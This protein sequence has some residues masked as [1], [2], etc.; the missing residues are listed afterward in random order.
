MNAGELKVVLKLDD[1]KFNASLIDA[2]GKVKSFGDSAEKS[3]D[4]ADGSFGRLAKNGLKYAALG[5]AGFASVVGG[6]AIKGG[7]SRALDIEDAQAKLKGL[8]HDASSVGGIMESALASVKGTAYGLDAAAT[9]AAT[10]V[11]AGVKPGK[12]LTKYLSLAADAATIAG[13]SMGDMG[14][15][16]NKV[17]TVNAAYNDS[18]LE[19]SEKGLPVYQWLSKE[20][21]VSTEQVKKLAS[22]G[23]VSSE[24]FQKAIENNIAGAALASGNTFRGAWANLL[25]SLS[26]IGQQIVTGPLN[27]LRD[28]F[29]SLTK[30]IDDNS[31]TI[32]GVVS[33]LFDSLSVIATGDFKGGMFGG[34]I[35]EDSKYVDILLKVHDA[36]G[37]VA[38]S[39]KVLVTGDFSKGMFG[40]ALSEDSKYVDMLFDI[41]D[42]IGK[43]KDA[44]GDMGTSLA[45]GNYNKLGEQIGSGIAKSVEV[46]FKGLSIGA[47]TLKSWFSRIDWGK[48]GVDIGTG[49]IAFVLGLVVGLFSTEALSAAASFIASNWQAVLITAITIAFLPAKLLGPVGA[50]M[51]KFTGPLGKLFANSIVAPIRGLVEPIRG[52]FGFIFDGLAGS[53][54]G[55]VATVGNIFK[56]FGMI[57]IAPVKIAIDYIA[58]LIWSLPAAIQQSLGAMASIAKTGLAF[59]WDAFVSVFSPAVGWFGG[60][61]RGAWGAIVNAFSGVAGFFSGVWGTIVGIFGRIGVA[62]G[63]AIGGTFKSAINSVLRGAVNLINGFIH[64]INDVVGI[65]NKIPGVK[66]GKIGD[67]GIP[68]LAAGGIVTAPTLAVIGEGSESEAVLPLSKLKALLD[69]SDSSGSR[70]NDPVEI[71]QNVYPQTPV[72]MNII[73]RSLMREARRA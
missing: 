32:V 73:N 14:R 23:K 57:V 18:L 40:G 53:A 70:G 4:K 2:E 50:A 72:D 38:D 12:D 45:G 65:I 31:K 60:I 55:A 17:Q 68:Q 44:I 67:L 19:L 66:I 8:G 64:T 26:R 52:A 30:F 62:V 7:I 63:D 9:T 43:V 34:M 36:V 46:A 29:G 56:T 28:S 69:E 41:R 20:M 13:T 47:D 24:I 1:G 6:L 27:F 42:S 39:A 16:F 33:S 58:T 71:T 25:A 61:F 5:M 35:Q 15:I 21:G 54:S 22:E 51:A 49:A 11:A 10:A 37:L 3:N 59:V 48:L